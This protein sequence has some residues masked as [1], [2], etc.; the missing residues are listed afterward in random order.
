MNNFKKK[1]LLEASE[2]NFHSK[3]VI[4]NEYR[5]HYNNLKNDLYSHLNTLKSCSK[6]YTR[7][8]GDKNFVEFYLDV[9]NCCKPFFEDINIFT[10][11]KPN[12][13]VNSLLQYE[14]FINEFE[15]FDDIYDLRDL[16]AP[17]NSMIKI[18][19]KFRKLK[20]E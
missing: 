17:I 10:S 19:P 18:L 6:N 7:S 4:P 3:P 11:V 8:C 15:A 13:L 16:K 9:E 12:N 20:Y 5:E 1:L 2:N 14:K